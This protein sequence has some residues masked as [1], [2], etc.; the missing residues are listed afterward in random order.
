MAIKGRA[1]VALI[2]AGEDSSIPSHRGMTHPE[3]GNQRTG[4][5]RIPLI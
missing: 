4:G 3:A 1:I 5:K 2:S